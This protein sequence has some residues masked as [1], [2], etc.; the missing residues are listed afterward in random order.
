MLKLSRLG[1]VVAAVAVCICATHA[2]GWVQLSDAKAAAVVGSGEGWFQACNQYL[3]CRGGCIGP[4]G[5]DYYQ[6]DD[7]PYMA[8]GLHWWRGQW[9]DTQVTCWKRWYSHR[10]EHGNCINPVGEPEP[11]VRAAC[12]PLGGN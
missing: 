8:V 3:N 11:E 2:D 4:F 10:D 12:R 9:Q 5:G 7:Q 1:I 6:Y